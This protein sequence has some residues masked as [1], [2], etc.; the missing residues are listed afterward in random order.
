ML[1]TWGTAKPAANAAAVLM[2]R[3]RDSE[4]P[5]TGNSV[6]GDLGMTLS[7]EGGSARLRNHLKISMG[8]ERSNGD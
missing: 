7:F 8:G 4:A 1:S 5:V 3:R 2:A 6:K